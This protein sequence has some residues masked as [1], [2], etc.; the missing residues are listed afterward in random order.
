VRAAAIRRAGL[1]AS[2]L[3]TGCLAWTSQVLAAETSPGASS[4]GSESAATDQMV[5]VWVIL[6]EPALATLPR[7]ATEQR[8]ALREKILKQQNEVMT[9]LAALGATESGRTQQ[10]SNALAVKLPAAA[11]E[12]AKSIEGVV[13][14]RPVTHRN[15]I[16]DRR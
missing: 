10:M 3:W 1:C 2:I 4:P 11:V 6:S 15:H 5:E 8:T 9:H 16:N 12:R 14:V 13:M 7:E